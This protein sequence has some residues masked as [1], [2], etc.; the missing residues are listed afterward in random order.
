MMWSLR[1]YALVL[2]AV[3]VARASYRGALQNLD[4]DISGWAGLIAFWIPLVG[5]LWIGASL[6]VPVVTRWVKK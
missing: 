1:P 6:L 5:M 3:L 2:C 4:G